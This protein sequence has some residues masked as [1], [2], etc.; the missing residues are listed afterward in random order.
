VI[1]HEVL[2]VDLPAKEEFPWVA[3]FHAAMRNYTERKL[4]EAEQLFEEAIKLRGGSDGPAEFY[5][6]QIAAAR[7]NLPDVAS[8]DG[9]VVIASK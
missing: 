8:W 2:G 9:V 3:T 6:K 4:D 7:L 1:V 5:L